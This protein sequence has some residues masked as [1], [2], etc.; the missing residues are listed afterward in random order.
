MSFRK[1]SSARVVIFRPTRGFIAAT[2]SPYCW[3]S[4]AGGIRA[5]LQTLARHPDHWP[6]AAF[7]NHDVT[8]T[9]TR[10]GPGSAKVMLALL[11]AL[12][13]TVLLYQGEE[14]GLP[15]VELERDQLRDP[16]G[17][18]YYPL[19]KGRDGCRTPMPWDAAKPNLGFSTGLPWLPLG[20]EHAALSVA[21]QERDANST[22]A[23]TRA[24]NS[25]RKSHASL[26][27]ADLILRDAPAPLM[28]FQRGEILCVFNLGRLE[29][30]WAAPGD[31]ASL[32]FG[33]G[34]VSLSGRMLTLGPLSAWF[35]R[36]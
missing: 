21:A 3:R 12:R 7:S 4:D 28:A 10:F 35:G 13:G 17:D 16:V 15:E 11:S 20:P 5:H 9:A 19:F 24:A 31:V 8:R 2:I 33:T 36:L 26:V 23:F 25:F 29:E 14:L 34:E 6:A 32:G 18:L 30:K 22:L 1:S 27:H